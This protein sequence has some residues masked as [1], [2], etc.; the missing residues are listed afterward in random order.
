MSEEGSGPAPM[1]HIEV[2]AGKPL[3]KLASSR[4]EVVEKSESCA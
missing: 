1:V 4:G 2:D 3:E